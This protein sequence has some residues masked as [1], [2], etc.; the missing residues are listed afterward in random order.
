MVRRKLTQ[1]HG[2]RQRKALAGPVFSY[3]ETQTGR[4]VVLLSCPP[5]I[6]W[7]GWRRRHRALE[8]V[9]VHGW[10]VALEKDEERG[11]RREERTRGAESE[12][13]RGS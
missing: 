4:V 7:P 13:E 9:W 6:L 3:T 1:R 12:S 8:E 2:C 11:E 10:A 5:V